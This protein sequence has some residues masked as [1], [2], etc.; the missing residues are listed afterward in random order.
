M[1]KW[2]ILS[3]I[4]V[5]ALACGVGAKV[6]WDMTSPDDRIDGTR[7][8]YWIGTDTANKTS[9]DVP[10]PTLSDT[11][12]QTLEFT[13]PNSTFTVGTTYQFVAYFYDNDENLIS[14]PSNTYE[15]IATEAPILIRVIQSPG[16]FHMELL[17]TVTQ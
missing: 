5:P 15:W 8:E 6:Q 7:I 1:K 2:S 16:N 13:F 12:P 10:L 4:A 3:L 9:V 11:Y 14:G 17:P